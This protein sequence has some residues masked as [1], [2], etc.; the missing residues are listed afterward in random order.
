MQWLLLLWLGVVCGRVGDDN[1]TSGLHGC[2]CLSSSMESHEEE[3]ECHCTGDGSDT[4]QPGV[5]R[6]ILSDPNITV[7]HRGLLQP[8]AQ[9]LRDVTLT[10]VEVLEPGAFSDLRHLR[11]IYISEVQSLKEL[12]G[13]FLEG[14][15]PSFVTLRVVRTGLQK[16]PN[17]RGLWR[18]TIMHMIDLEANRIAILGSNALHVKA[19][20]VMLNYNA[21]EAVESWAFNGSQIGKLDLSETAIIQLPTS[22]LETL[23]VLRIRNTESLTTIPSVYSFKHLREAWLTYSFHCCAFKFPARHDPVRHAQHQA[24]LA[25]MRKYCHETYNH[26]DVRRRRS[27]HYDVFGPL[28]DGYRADQPPE[29]STDLAEHEN[30]NE[31]ESWHDIEFGEDEE[32]QSEYG[33]FHYTT[34]APRRIHVPACGNISARAAVRCYPE[35]DALNPCE[36][37][38]GSIWLRLSVWVVVITAVLGNA[39]VLVVTIGAA[40]DFNPPK[41]LMC[42]LAFADLCMGF[43]LLLLASADAHSQGAYFNFAYRWQRGAGCQVAGFLTVFASQLSVYTLTILTL[44]RWVAITYALYLNKRLKLRASAHLMTAG[45]L[46]SLTMAVLPLVGISNYSA[47]SICLPMETGK[48]MDIAYLVALLVMNGLAF[49]V[50]CVCYAQI[51]L[52]LGRETR[53]GGGASRRLGEMTVAKRMALL[54]F[55][56]FAC[57]APIAF[58][59]LTAVAGYPLIDVTRSKILLVFFYPL[60]SC[61]NPYLYAL[62][63]KQYRRDLII[64]LTRCGLT[65]TPRGALSLATT[66]NAHPM[67]LLRRSADASA[68]GTTSADPFSNQE[69]LL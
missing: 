18:E 37:I 9:S 51:Y 1:S 10:H 23:E 54:I 48:T 55:T 42:H 2:H 34:V 60:N 65:R 30:Y 41:F 20:Q 69:A 28:D 36:D 57:W 39:A 49:L 17:L 52:S 66:H 19:H 33:T 22:G 46:Y 3:M 40:H 50:V 12:P 14:V 26:T 8:F 27:W 5:H 44:E 68:T 6:L 45:W 25:A 67:P 7:L 4:V 13:G 58:F 35:P 56:D 59:G 53:R 15:S 63:T 29:D 24:Y 38:M 31:M 43:Y 64:M 11:T 47:T 21:I 62:L 32:D 16:I 61:A